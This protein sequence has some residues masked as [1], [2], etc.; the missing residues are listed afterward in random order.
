MRR[1]RFGKA[2][3]EETGRARR[4]FTLIE[5]LVVIAIIAILA[6]LLLPA[7]S[8]AKRRAQG[9][10]CMNNMRQ[11]QLAAIQYGLDSND[12][13][14]LNEGHPEG[15][16]PIG[17]A[18]KD[19]D[20]VAGS[21]GT[22]GDNPYIPPPNGSPVGCETNVCLLGV[23]GNDVPGQPQPLAGSIGGYSKNPGV[24]KCPADL[25]TWKSGA[26]VYPR[27]R[28]CS[29]NCYMG[30]TAYEQTDGN[31]IQAKYYIFRKFSNFPAGLGPA[32]AMTIVDENPHSINDG[33]LLI[34]EPGGGNDHPAINHGQS[35]SI[36]FADGHATLHKWH[37]ALLKAPAGS[38]G[39]DLAWL[40]AH[41]S[42]KTQ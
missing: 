17:F 15:T 39:S 6:A 33:F 24:Y 3:P 19:A 41:V 34:D 27:V 38:S 9:I 16:T 5:L 20:W 22:V 21:F 8:Q 23:W 32:D 26:N 7:L 11:L 4:G 12:A 30:T 35:S 18:P 29:M 36:T 10:S 1:Q 25:S 42:I 40:A 2:A 37:D 31:E 14:P 13:I 28:S